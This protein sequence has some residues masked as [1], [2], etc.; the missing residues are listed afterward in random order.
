MEGVGKAENGQVGGTR[1]GV[2]EARG[3]FL[4]GPLNTLT[5]LLSSVEH[6]GSLVGQLIGLRTRLGGED[7]VQ[8]LGGGPKETILQDIVPLAGGEVT[9]SRTVDQGRDKLRG[10]SGLDQSRV[11]V[12]NRNGGNLRVA[13]LKVLDTKPQ[14]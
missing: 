13:V 5:T 8:S 9:Q 14:A 4:L 6:H 2:V 7:L 12:A 1:L 10:L 3:D 11:V